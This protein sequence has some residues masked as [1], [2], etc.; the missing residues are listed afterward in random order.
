MKK[1]I[2]GWDFPFPTRYETKPMEEPEVEGMIEKI[3]TSFIEKCGELDI[4]TEV[5]EA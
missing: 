3:R 5:V 2:F 1:I 4:I